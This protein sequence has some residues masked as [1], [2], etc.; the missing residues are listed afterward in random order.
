M[1]VRGVSEQALQARV[2]PAP[3]PEAERSKA[4]AETEPVRAGTASPSNRETSSASDTVV[5]ER[6]KA[7]RAGTKLRVDSESNRIVAQIIDES[8]RVMKQIPPE[9]MLRIAAKFR[10]LQ[11]LLFDQEA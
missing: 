1:G 9:E 8:N 3:V 2:S 4:A 10:E 7:Q 6:P 11:G 5:R